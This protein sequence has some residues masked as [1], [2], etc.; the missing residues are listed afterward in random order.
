LEFFST[1]GI[2]PIAARKALSKNN[3]NLAFKAI[4]YTTFAH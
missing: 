1:Y 3:L 2:I 4:E